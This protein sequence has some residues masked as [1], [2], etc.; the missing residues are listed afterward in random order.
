MEDHVHGDDGHVVVADAPDIEIIEAPSTSSDDVRIAEI[1]A[2]KEIALAKLQLKAV[3]PDLEIALA[4]ALAEIEA[5]K[6]AMA[7]PEPAPIVI[8]APEVAEP[9]SEPVEQES[10]PEPEDVTEHQEHKRKSVGL[11]MW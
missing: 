10:L 2:E 7:P 5:L 1:Q 8:E 11:G 4:A 6:L 9:V 3:E